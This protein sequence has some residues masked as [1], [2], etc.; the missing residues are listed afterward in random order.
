MYKH[1]IRRAD[2]DAHAVDFLDKYLNDGWV[3]LSHIV[4][5]SEMDKFYTLSSSKSQHVLVFQKF[6]QEKYDTVSEETLTQAK[7]DEM[8]FEDVFGSS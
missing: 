3:L 5:P 2:W 4:Y 7:L 6:I 1:K 8:A